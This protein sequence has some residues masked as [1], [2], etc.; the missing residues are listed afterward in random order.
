VSS[1]TTEDTEGTEISIKGIPLRDWFAGMALQ[2]IISGSAH[3]MFDYEGDNAGLVEDSIQSALING[4]GK[5]D[6][7][8]TSIRTIWAWTAYCVA[9]AMLKQRAKREME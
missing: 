4:T 1:L 6:P 9:D 3:P 8:S 7:E 2:G 5:L